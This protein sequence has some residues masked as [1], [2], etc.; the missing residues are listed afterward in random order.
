MHGLLQTGCTIFFT[1]EILEKILIL[2]AVIHLVFRLFWL[3]LRFFMQMSGHT[4][5][6]RNN[7]CILF[8]IFKMLRRGF[9]LAFL[10][11]FTLAYYSIRFRVCQYI[12]CLI[13]KVSRHC[14]LP[15]RQPPGEAVR[16]NSDFGFCLTGICCLHPAIPHRSACSLAR[17]GDSV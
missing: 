17:L 11:T 8:L 5:E 10:N 1:M 14:F 2:I 15:H 7:G 6:P 9:G 16:N 3:F 13:F 12:F 4:H